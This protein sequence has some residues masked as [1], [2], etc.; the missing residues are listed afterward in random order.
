MKNKSKGPPGGGTGRDVLEGGFWFWFWLT[1]AIS[2]QGS[3]GLGGPMHPLV[4][5][6]STQTASEALFTGVHIKS[7]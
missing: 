1:R 2:W 7:S 3:D 4:V 5:S 6:I